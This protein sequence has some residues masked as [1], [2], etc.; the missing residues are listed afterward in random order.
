MRNKA[1]AFLAALGILL[2]LCAPARAQFDAQATYVGSSGGTGTAVTILVANVTQLSDLIGVPIRVLMTQSITGAS[3]LQVNSLPATAVNKKTPAGLAAT[4]NGDIVAGQMGVYTY[5]GTV[6]E[7]EG[8]QLNLQTV[9]ASS[10]FTEAVN[11]QLNCSAAANALTCAIKAANTAGDPSALAP[12]YIPFA[13]STT[14]SGDPVW[15]TITAATSFTFAGGNT[16]GCLSASPCRLWITAIDNSGTVLLG[17]SNQSV[18]G[19][20]FPLNEAVLQTTGSGTSGG[21]TV[22]TIYTSV[23]A[24]SSKAIRILGYVEWTTLTTAGNWTAPNFVRL[25]GPGVKKPCDMVQGPVVATATASVSSTSSTKVQ[26][27]P[28]VSITPSSAANLIRAHV[29]GT[30]ETFASGTTCLMAISRST[31]FTALTAAA[32]MAVTTSSGT[33]LNTQF[34]VPITGV[35]MPATTSP[36]TYVPFIWSGSSVTCTWNSVGTPTSF[37]EVYEIMGALPAND[38]DPELRMAG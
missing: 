7:L 10:G 12:V 24:V 9:Q 18:S 28:S 36:T 22:G 14:T 27:N 26:A 30:I 32:Q 25:F 5:D 6:F 38:N 15:R 29:D 11:L 3:T 13:D 16:A 20:C 21:N 23:S 1:Y 33:T 35:D 34:P 37:I 17:L 8:P 2:S 4:V 19:S 31:S